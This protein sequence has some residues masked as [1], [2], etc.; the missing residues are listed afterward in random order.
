MISPSLRMNGGWLERQTHPSRQKHASG[1]SMANIAGFS[2]QKCRYVTTQIGSTGGLEPDMTSMTASKLT[3]GFSKKSGSF[4]PLSRQFL[5]SWQPLY[6]MAP[7]I[8]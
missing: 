3:R 2:S 4:E 5:P 6:L 7:L 8:S 1:D